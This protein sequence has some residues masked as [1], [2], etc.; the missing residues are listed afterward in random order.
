M[1]Y[2]DIVYPIHDAL[3]GEICIFRLLQDT[4]KLNENEAFLYN[5]VTQRLF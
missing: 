4:K 2:T 3:V 1:L 5:L